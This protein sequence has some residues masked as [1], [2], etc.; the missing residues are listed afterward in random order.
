MV[1]SGDSFNVG[2]YVR[3]RSNPG[4]AGTI[5][6]GVEEDAGDRMWPV[7]LPNGIV[8]KWEEGFFERVPQRETIRDQL[9]AGKF[10]KKVDFSQAV[11]YHRLVL[12]LSNHIY[13]LHAN[14]IDFLPYQ[15]K[16]LLKFLDSPR[17][18][19]LVADDVGLGKTIEAGIILSELKLQSPVQ[20]VLIVCPSHLR[21]KWRMEMLRK[22][23]EE[24]Q[25]MESKDLRR[26]LSDQREVPGEGSVRLICSLQMM[27]SPKMLRDIEQSDPRFDLVVVD[28]GHHMRNQDT[29]HH[30]VGALLSRLTES[31]VMLTATP[32]QTKLENL[33]QL[34]HILD[35]DHFMRADEFGD[36]IEVNKLV[37][38]ADKALANHP[39]NPE[40]FRATLERIN[41][42]PVWQRTWFEENPSW[43]SLYENAGK[44]NGFSKTDVAEFR[45]Q[46][47]EINLLGDHLTRTRKVDARTE[48][49]Q[50]EPQVLKITYSREERDIYE[51]MLDYVRKNYPVGGT[52]FEKAALMMPQR[53]AASSIIGA[54]RFYASGK[55]QI[56]L[57]EYLAGVDTEYEDWYQDE[58]LENVS[59]LR[60]VYESAAKGLIQDTKYNALIG[61]LRG[62]E[63]E[64]KIVLF[65]TF[66]STLEYLQGV[67][68]QDG[69]QSLV[70]SGQV[71]PEERL[72]RIQEFK[73]QPDVR[74]LLSS[75]VG[76]EGLDMQFA[77]I[78]VNYD[79]PW[80]PMVVAQRI[81]RLDRIG[82]KAEK[83]RVIN[84]CVEDTIDEV[85][86]ERLY[87]RIG[88]FESTIG[89]MDGILG[90]VLV[91]IADTLY[92]P[93]LL[94]EQR[95]L[96]MEQEAQALEN[97]IRMM[98]EMKDNAT[99][100]LIGDHILQEKIE[101][102]D[103]L[104]RYV[105]GEDLR[106]LVSEFLCLKFPKSTLIPAKDKPF[107]YTFDPDSALRAA[108]RDFHF[109]PG[110]P[111]PAFLH[112]VGM[113]NLITFEVEV[114]KIHAGVE[115]I[116]ASHPLT[117]MVIQ[118]YRDE[119]E[120]FHRTTCFRAKLK[121]VAPGRYLLVVRKA[122]CQGIRSYTQLLQA[123]VDLRTLE[124]YPD[125]KAEL[126]MVECV[127]GGL[128]F[129]HATRPPSDLPLAKAYETAERH[130]M[131]KMAGLRHERKNK[132]A[133]YRSRREA[134]K[135]AYYDGK[136][137]R[138]RELVEEHGRLQSP[139]ATIKGF[140]TQ[141][142]RLERE[143]EEILH[144]IQ[145]GSPFDFDDDEVLAAVVMV[146]A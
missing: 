124:I 72:R 105:G 57:E 44:P 31:M 36:L 3:K 26:W 135:R 123:L 110:E 37:V 10:G 142:E 88:L 141:A 98:R 80:N 102:A 46:L 86:L 64:S 83:I 107:V 127:T 126:F 32:V 104:H 70:I 129:P 87:N 140:K 76:G 49:A 60:D 93:D 66:P 19:L 82:Q 100:T 63:P 120:P 109:A 75:E 39:P 27:R 18:R 8:S 99:S 13:S 130:L 94:P 112:G 133:S 59:D 52:F 117:R 23:G 101:Q 45:F 54:A 95:L 128:D 111:R 41:R 21:E 40:F 15:F 106:T 125:E 20:R 92:S 81:G 85:I 9:V 118:R 7:L 16:P 33:Y 103:Q 121:D 71:H 139:P 29:L 137:R 30:Q 2:D 61:F 77:S 43:R 143:K 115:H 17:Q 136:I 114:A 58:T 25:I 53:R 65:S 11:T 97:N 38:E 84:M 4:K 89:L 131:E 68:K 1:P 34:L 62:V 119:G 47:S 22:F 146:E 138:L 12:P 73:V 108:F 74:V 79:L 35:P 145:F 144:Q 5:V 14:R 6:G 28:E 90:D 113:G 78:V 69:V 56:N 50:R 122:L 132:D 96:K 55:G 67:L 24:F 116:T 48:F 134:G 91:K 42:L 51:M